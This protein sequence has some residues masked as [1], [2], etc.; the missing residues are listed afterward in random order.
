MLFFV[1][2]D[3]D[4]V[5]SGDGLGLKEGS[6]VGKTKQ[7]EASVQVVWLAD[8]GLGLKIMLKFVKV[9]K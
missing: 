1:V 9:D 4:S 5:D 2:S 3:N 6:Q 8:F 7:H